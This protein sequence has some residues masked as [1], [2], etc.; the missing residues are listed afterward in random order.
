MLSFYRQGTDRSHDL[1]PQEAQEL[2]QT[3]I[4][5]KQEIVRTTALLWKAD[6]NLDTPIL[7]FFF[8][9]ISHRMHIQAY[10]YSHT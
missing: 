6:I 10:I 4:C 1:V 7:S 3:C 9:F 8:R 5:V 2:L